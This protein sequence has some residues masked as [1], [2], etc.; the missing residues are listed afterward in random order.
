MPKK[1]DY[2]LRLMS[3][4]WAGVY[5]NYVVIAYPTNKNTPEI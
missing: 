3:F 5:S 2:K 4:F 1:L